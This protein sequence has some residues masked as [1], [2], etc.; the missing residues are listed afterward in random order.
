MIYC[1]RFRSFVR[2]FSPF[3]SVLSGSHIIFL[4][5]NKIVRCDKMRNRYE[6]K[7]RVL[8]EAWQSIRIMRKEWK[9]SLVFV[10]RGLMLQLLLKW[11]GLIRL[12]FRLFE[13]EVF[14]LQSV[15]VGN[16]IEKQILQWRRWFIV[17][18][19]SW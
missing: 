13:E 8:R 9:L 3:S 11:K 7:C 5:P 14:Y 6:M 10:P 17:L 12:W 16:I 18:K 1:R 15:I 2:S 19:I 4:S